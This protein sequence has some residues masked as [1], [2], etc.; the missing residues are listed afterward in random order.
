MQTTQ[1]ITNPLGLDLADATGY[2]T[3][4]DYYDADR[5]TE[6]ATDMAHNGW[7]G[8]PLVVIP[9]YAVSYSGTHRL[10]AAKEAELEEVPAV[11]LHDLF[12]ACGLDL[13]QIT[14]DED[15]SL[16]ADRV[17]ILL[18]LPDDIRETYAIDDIC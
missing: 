16:V 17:E 8:A 12:A 4:Q 11:S 6:I 2:T 15:L 13:D 18:H 10:R 9:D 7:H 1:G 14:A 5:V 3:G